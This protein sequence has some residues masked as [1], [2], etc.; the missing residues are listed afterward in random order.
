MI[1]FG[2]VLTTL[3]KPMF[4]GSGAVYAA[5]GTVATLYWVTA[6]A[7][8]M[9]P[10]C[11]SPYLRSTGISSLRVTMPLCGGPRL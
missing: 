5:F 6:G 7:L 3:N 2:T 9:P 8:T 11:K 1:I 4:A 10:H